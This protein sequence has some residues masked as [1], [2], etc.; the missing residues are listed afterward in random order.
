MSVQLRL[1]DACCGVGG[2]S[3][4][5]R[6]HGW[7]V[8][9]VD[10]EP[11]FKPTVVADIR[12]FD[13]TPYGPFD[14]ALGSPPCEAFSVMNIGKNWTRDPATGELTPKHERARLGLEIALATRRVC[15]IA[16]PARFLLEN[17]WAALRKTKA[18]TDL[19]RVTVSYCQYGLRRQKPTDLWGYPPAGW[20]PRPICGKGAPCH[21]A[22]PRG[23]ATGHVSRADRAEV[24][25]IPYQLADSVREACEAENEALLSRALADD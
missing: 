24:A 15:E 16:S 5:F 10:I 19:P 4:P 1:L 14:L 9:T 13:P 18:Y 20:V 2:W 23:S 21:D 12:S 22:A 8:V 17:P 7:E 11:S 6:D 25:R 3:A